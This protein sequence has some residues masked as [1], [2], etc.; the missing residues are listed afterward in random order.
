MTRLTLAFLPLAAALAAGLAPAARADRLVLVD[1]RVVEGVVTKDGDSYRVVSRF[2]ESVLAAKDV[3]EWTK[4][5]TVDEEWRARAAA[6][7]P[8]DF[9][10]R[11]ALAQWLKDAGRPEAAEATAAAVLES[12]PENAVAHAV[13]GHV[14]HQG[15]WMTP[16][17]A[18]IADG[19]ER[20]GDRWYTPEEWAVLD[21]AA[22]E[23]A[24]AAERQA[25]GARVTA[26][27]N[28]AV[29]LVLSPD[30]K[31]REAGLSRLRA[32]AAETKNAEIE[33]LIPQVKAYAE[34]G[35]RLAA[36][37]AGGGG[38][39]SE[40]ATVLAECRITLARL[41]RPIQ[42]FTTSLGSN[43]STAPV[44]IQLPELEVIRI[45]TTV[46]IPAAVDK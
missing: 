9:A 46:P 42:N 15:R 10:G 24:E 6:A 26:R 5:R 20:H 30:P 13:L 39:A 43:L 14:R 1:G 22:R 3:K 45:G 25:R 37:V 23:K 35:D 31:A 19:L 11:A 36:L 18:K 33:R 8:D 34:Q 38:E 44:T 12:D 27:L 28:D 2:G 4:G 32:L 17:E 16:D 21:G 40:S 29:R 7:K 41:K